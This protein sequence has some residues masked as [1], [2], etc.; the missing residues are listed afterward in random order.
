[1]TAFSPS[2]AS[3]LT[4][5]F[6][7]LIY[8]RYV[9]VKGFMSLYNNTPSIADIPSGRKATTKCAFKE[10]VRGDQ[11]G[12]LTYADIDIGVRY[13]SFL[14]PSTT[15]RFRFILSRTENGSWRWDRQS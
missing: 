9:E 1:M 10:G 5:A 11:W 12:A 15:D 6:Q 14:W 8:E 2:R 7:M 13:E 3:R 4:A